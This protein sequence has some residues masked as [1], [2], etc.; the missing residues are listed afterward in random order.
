MRKSTQE[1]DLMKEIELLQSQVEAMEAKLARKK[2]EL[3][4]LES[5]PKFLEMIDEDD[6]Q[7]YNKAL[8]RAKAVLNVR[9]IPDI[10]FLHVRAEGEYKNKGFYLCDRDLNGM[11]T[12][13][14][15]SRNCQV[16]VPVQNVQK[17]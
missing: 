13:V 8:N 1:K 4:K 6:V 11:W 12:V 15:D 16:L 10:E 7:E 17:K 9:A 14:T 5:Q 3:D 2:C